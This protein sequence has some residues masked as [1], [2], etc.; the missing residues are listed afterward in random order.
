MSAYFMFINVFNNFQTRKLILAGQDATAQ[1]AAYYAQIY[2]QQ[3]GTPAAAAAPAP[4][5]SQSSSDYTK[6]WV[7]YYRAYGMTKEAEMIEQM[8]KQVRQ[9]IDKVHKIY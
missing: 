6:Q 4:D 7:D 8:A 1:W 9:S 2:A 5:A 3:G